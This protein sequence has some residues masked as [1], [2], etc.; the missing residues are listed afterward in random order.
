MEALV[1]ESIDLNADVGEGCANDADLFAFVTTANV[2]CGAHA[3]D[4]ATM[5]ETVRAAIRR[6]V[7]IGAHPGFPDREHFGRI[8]LARTPQQIY[9]DVRTQVD[10]LAQIAR[11]EGVR[12][13]HV[14]PHGALYNMAARSDPLAE[15]IAASI[16]DYDPSLALVGL[17][18]SASIHAARR[19]GLRA[20]EEVFAD[21]G[22]AKDGTLLPRGTPGALIDDPNAAVAQA[23][24]FVE[25]GFGETICLH[26]DGPHAVEFARRIRTALIDAGV[27]VQSF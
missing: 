22:Y 11:R 1:R 10:A 6:N 7:S 13:H 12:I 19:A 4:E 27:T 23:V 21:R 17:A 20:V 9:E 15:A 26:G 24:A 14:K 3:G 18:G 5:T 16:R 25:R 8:E 2:A